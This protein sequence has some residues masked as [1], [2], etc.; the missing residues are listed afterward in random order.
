M[1]VNSPFIMCPSDESNR[2][3]NSVLGLSASDHAIYFGK[4]M[5]N[6]GRDGCPGLVVPPPPPGA[7]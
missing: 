1:S 4:H 2:C 6:F 3:S 5:N 7:N